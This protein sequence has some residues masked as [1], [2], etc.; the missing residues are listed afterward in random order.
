VKSARRNRP[1]RA[2]FG[3]VLWRYRLYIVLMALPA[4]SLC[5]GCACVEITGIESGGVVGVAPNGIKGIDVQPDSIT[6]VEAD[7][8]KGVDV[9]PGSVTGV[10]SGAVST[11]AVDVHD[12]D[13]TAVNT[14]DVGNGN[15]NGNGNDNGQPSGTIIADGTTVAVAEGGSV[16]TTAQD[17]VAELEPERPPTNDEQQ[18]VAATE[19]TTSTADDKARELADEIERSIAALGPNPTGEQVQQAIAAARQRV[20]LP[21]TTTDTD[22][23]S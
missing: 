12:N 9:Q 18:A 17:G 15:G 22:E 19:G 21:A 14:G 16:T 5:S 10:E 7:G 3:S 23:Q 1:C 20:G 13:P 6:G 4:M 8:V 2:G 11:G